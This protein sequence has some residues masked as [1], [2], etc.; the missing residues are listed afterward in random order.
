MT[1]HIWNRA[2]GGT[3]VALAEFHDAVSGVQVNDNVA[4]LSAMSGSTN[5]LPAGNYQITL[6]YL[7]SKGQNAAADFVAN[8]LIDG[9]SVTAW[10]GDLHRAEPVDA[11]GRSVSGTETN[12]SYPATFTFTRALATGTHSYDFLFGP[13]F[14]G[15]RCSVRDLSISF[16][17]LP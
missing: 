13:E 7:W 8:L 2:G 9:T 10:G 14:D 15:E 4:A 11:A 6:S 3:A 16:R 12:Q 1:N 5:V 17:E